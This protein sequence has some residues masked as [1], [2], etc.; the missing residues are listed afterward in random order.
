MLTNVIAVV[1][2]VVTIACLVWYA[3]SWYKVM[4]DYDVD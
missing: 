4:V 1:L 3:H 2:L